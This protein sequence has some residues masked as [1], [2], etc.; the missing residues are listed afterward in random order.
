MEKYFETVELQKK[1][2]KHFTEYVGKECNYD[3]QKSVEMI[4]SVV[5]TLLSIGTIVSCGKDIKEQEKFIEIIMKTIKC[6]IDVYNK[7]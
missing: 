7:Q 6:K 3:K 2:L 1:I 5:I 4:L